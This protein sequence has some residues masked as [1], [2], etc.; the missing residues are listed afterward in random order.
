MMYQTVPANTSGW[1]TR[2]KC[3][4]C[5]ALADGEVEYRFEVDT[6]GRRQGVVKEQYYYCQDCAEMMHERYTIDSVIDGNIE[7]PES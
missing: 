5:G 1:Y 4:R 6:A 7:L 3:D 2:E